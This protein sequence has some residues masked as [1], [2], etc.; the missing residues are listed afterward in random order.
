[1]RVASLLTDN[2]QLISKTLPQQLKL[3]NQ[4]TLQLVQ[5]ERMMSGSK[6]VLPNSDVEEYSGAV[7]CSTVLR[8]ANP[9]GMILFRYTSFDSPVGRKD[10]YFYSSDNRPSWWPKDVAFCSI[11]GT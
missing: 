7:L 3:V 8:I 9:E 10:R 6:I 5:R 2:L 1:M 4:K 11:T